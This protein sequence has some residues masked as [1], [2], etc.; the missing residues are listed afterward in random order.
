MWKPG[1]ERPK[2]GRKADADGNKLKSNQS[3]PVVVK[4]LSSGTMNMRFMQR[5]TVTP[6]QIQPQKRTEQE[7]TIK[8]TLETAPMDVESDGSVA[9][10]DDSTTSSPF[11]M[12]TAQDMYGPV[13]MG[14]RSFGGFRPVVE[15]MHQQAAGSVSQDEGKRKRKR[16][17]K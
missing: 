7:E 9:H 13:I 16:S 5:N 11:V 12:A 4:K 10:N 8:R 6:K 1:S 15:Q 3:P 14:R 2:K 17:K